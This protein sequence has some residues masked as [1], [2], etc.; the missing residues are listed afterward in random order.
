MTSEIEDICVECGHGENEHMELGDRICQHY[1]DCRGFSNGSYD[2]HMYGSELEEIMDT[3]HIPMY[4][5]P[6]IEKRIK[7]MLIDAE[8]KGFKKARKIVQE[9]LAPTDEVAQ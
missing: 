4:M 6:N 2:T 3:S 7:R 9:S 1:D 5:R 8:L